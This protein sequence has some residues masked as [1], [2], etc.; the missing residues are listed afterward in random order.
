MKF[1]RYSIFPHQIRQI[2]KSQFLLGVELLHRDPLLVEVAGQGGDVPH[3]GVIHQ[4]R[5][6]HWAA[7][8]EAQDLEA[9]SQY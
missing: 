6:G 8:Q 3:V 7:V 4:S 9:K 1:D 2:K 5:E